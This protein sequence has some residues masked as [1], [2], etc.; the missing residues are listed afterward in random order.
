[1]RRILLLSVLLVAFTWSGYAQKHV[2]KRKTTNAP[3]SG[4][5]KKSS[6]SNTAGSS[7]NAVINSIINNMVYVQG[8][9]FMKGQVESYMTNSTSLMEETPPQRV[10]LSGFYIGRYE[11]TQREWRAVMGSNPSTHKGDKRPVD[12]VSWNDCQRFISK[13]N[14][15]SGR[16]FRLPTEAEWEFAARGG[17]KSRNY[18]YS[19][20]KSIDDVGWGLYNGSNTTHNV[21]LKR[22]NE[23]G[24]YDMTGNVAEWT[25]NWYDGSRTKYP[26]FQSCRVLR[27]GNWWGNFV[28]CSNFCRWPA[29]PSKRDGGFGLRLVMD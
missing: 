14:S 20:G 24:L 17:N 7:K 21:G 18:E 22:A 6:T 16:H 28:V 26:E 3:V 10:T 13:L 23:L 19:G 11:V 25:T 27:G 5:V 15:M 4:T 12:N 9:T 8:G 29:K 2:I 1:M